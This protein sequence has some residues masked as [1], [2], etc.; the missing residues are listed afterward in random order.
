M[1]GT[2]VNSKASADRIWEKWAV[3]HGLD[4]QEFLP[5]MHGSRSIDTLRRLNLPG[6]DPEHEAELIETA[7]AE[8]VG[9]VVEI[10]GGR[11]FLESL[12]A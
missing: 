2:I 4:V 10:P 1:D 12:P 3:D 9:E 6:V 7:E 5:K 8:D 11:A